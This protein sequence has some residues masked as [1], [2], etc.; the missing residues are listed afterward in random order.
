MIAKHVINIHMNRPT[1]DGAEAGG[2]GD[3]LDIDTMKRYVAYCKA[4]AAS[5][6]PPWATPRADGP[7][8]SARRG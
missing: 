3:E 2:Q 7:A 8:G 1:A 5:S 4:C 6:V